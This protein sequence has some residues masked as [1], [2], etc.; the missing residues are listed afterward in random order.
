VKTR[1]VILALLAFAQVSTWAGAMSGASP[2]AASG[3]IYRVGFLGA[4][5]RSTPANPDLY[6]DAWLDGMRDLGYVEG[7]NLVV[8]WR[9]AENKYERLPSLA[10][11]LAAMKLDVIVTH[12]VAPTLALQK[13]ART[14]PIVFTGMV[15]PVGSHVVSSLARPGGNTT[16]IS[17]MG[18]DVS[19][20][21]VEVLRELVPMLS[22]V[23]VLVNP[24][25]PSH[26]VML[27]SVQDA[28][29]I[30][31][32][33]VVPV[34]ARN[35]EEIES[36]LG[37]LARAHADGLI[38]LEDGTFLGYADLIA[39]FAMSHRIPAMLPGRESV[40]AG[41]LICYGMNVADC[42]RRAAVL[43]D[44]ILKGAKPADLPIEQP[45]K[46]ELVINRKTARALGLTIPPELLVQADRVIE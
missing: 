7:K 1:T 42:Y 43:V 15:D 39:R 38:V 10:A 28:G 32:I 6:Y 2:A 13:A 41:G 27:K 11:E 9:L 26:P 29:K 22:T 35:R 40:E 4:R 12:A 17:V 14:T 20:K 16:G 25:T 46:V 34:Q 45:T 3:K 37:T 33:G 19:A 36:G 44:K 30:F 24:D 5:F 21:R 23:A 31:G 8:E 18:T